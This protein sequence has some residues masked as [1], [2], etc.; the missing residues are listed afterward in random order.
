MTTRARSVIIPAVALLLAALTPAFAQDEPGSRDHPLVGRYDGARIVYYKSADYDEAALLQ[1]PHDYNALLERNDTKDRSGDDWLKLEGRVTK[2]RYEIP[3]GRSSLE[4]M[5]NYDNALKGRGFTSVFNC[6]DKACFKGVLQD[7]YLLGEQVDADNGDSGLYSGRVRY[8]LMRLDRAGGPVYVSL[9]AGE[10]KERITAF[11]TVVEAKPM[12]GEKIVFIDAGEMEREISQHRRVSLYGIVFDFD[13]DALRPESKPTL[14]EIAK[15]LRQRPNLR[16][17]IVGHT[18]NRG[19]AE[20]NINLSQRRAANVLS[21][22]VYQYGI[23]PV[24]LSS[25]GAGFTAPVASNETEE[26]RAKNRRV[27]LVAQ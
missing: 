22:L 24:R 10:D 5:R 23:A 25:R 15:L 17:D 3:A 14:D 12:A 9:L 16:L 6:V 2:I 27:E 18:D 11:V 20:Y 7:P 19:T 4:V 13:K 26:G 8:A 21:A 1:A